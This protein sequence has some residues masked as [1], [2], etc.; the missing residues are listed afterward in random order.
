MR[1]LLLL[2]ALGPNEAA[3][4]AFHVC[5]NYCGPG[6]CN[7]QWLG[8][9][10]CDDSSPVE[11]WSAT[12]QSCADLCCKAH[13]TCCGHEPPYRDCNKKIVACLSAC[14]P[15][16]L[17]CTLDDV[18]VPAG[19]IEAAMDIVEDWCCGSPCDDDA[20]LG[21]PDRIRRNTTGADRAAAV[22]TAAPSICPGGLLSECIAL[23][24][25]TPPIGYEACVE[26]CASRCS[27]V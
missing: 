5:G 3:A 22:G 8:E 13:D 10:D 9:T 16:S 25:S 26:S 2:C 6:W 14:N 17:T 19:G 24:P 20:L 27:T 15:A 11:T 7:G 1:A 4:Y 18:P 21:E 12:G 23:C